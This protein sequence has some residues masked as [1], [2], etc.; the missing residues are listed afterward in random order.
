MADT[1][2][3][4]EADPDDAAEAARR[5]GALAVSFAAGDVIYRPGDR[6]RGWI[7]L[8]SGRVK[9][10]LTADNGREVALYRIAAGESCVLTTA[11][12]F[13]GDSMLAEAVA[14]T[15]VQ[16]RLIP[17][18]VFERLIGESAEFRRVVLRNYAERVVD[19]VIVIQEALFHAVPERLAR[20][21]LAAARGGVVA[22]THQALAAELGTAR[23][24]VSRI[25]R[26]MEREGALESER[27]EIRIRNEALLRA[28]ARSQR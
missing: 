14:E 15:D 25:L 24:V 9:V 26:R 4:P 16:A 1:K 19:L 2:R 10:S 17:T 11:A 12:M 5:A 28:T 23:E 27:G 3:T 21:L 18:P 20:R 7:V 13:S 22:T 8:E 6:V